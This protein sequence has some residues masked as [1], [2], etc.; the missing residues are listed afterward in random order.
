MGGLPIISPGDRQRFRQKSMGRHE[1]SSGV[2]VSDRN[3]RWPTRAKELT[4]HSWEFRGP[5]GAREVGR[6]LSGSLC[7]VWLPAA[8]SGIQGTQSHVPLLRMQNLRG[9]RLAELGLWP[10]SDCAGRLGRVRRKEPQEPLGFHPKLS[11]TSVFPPQQCCALREKATLAAIQEGCQ[12]GVRVVGP[13]ECLV[14]CR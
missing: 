3:H 14:P 6:A 12:E 8:W 10:A 1:D 5:A 7:Q 13:A 2:S 9:V 11:Q 4:A